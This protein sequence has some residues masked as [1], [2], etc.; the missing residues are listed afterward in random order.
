LQTGTELWEES[1][2]DKG[3]FRFLQV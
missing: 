1:L 2:K 3:V